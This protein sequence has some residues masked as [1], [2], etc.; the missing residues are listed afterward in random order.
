MSTVRKS[1]REQ[2]EEENVRRYQAPTL[3]FKTTDLASLV[4]PY[5]KKA[6]SRMKRFYEESQRMDKKLPELIAKVEAAGYSIDKLTLNA[7]D[8]E[9]LLNYRKKTKS[10]SFDV[11]VTRDAYTFDG[12][13]T[14]TPASMNLTLNSGKLKRLYT[15]NGFVL[16]LLKVTYYRTLNVTDNYLSSL[17]GGSINTKVE[18]YEEIPF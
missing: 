6:T 18:E 3:E 1:R 17:V 16:P 4:A 11:V 15:K 5:K 12:K 2:R 7:V 13:L 8:K 9:Y 10:L 14:V